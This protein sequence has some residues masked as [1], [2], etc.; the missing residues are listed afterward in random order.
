MNE[1]RAATC[2]LL[3]LQDDATAAVRCLRRLVPGRRASKRRGERESVLAGVWHVGDGDVGSPPRAR[4][5]HRRHVLLRRTTG[6]AV[7]TQR[8]LPQVRNAMGN[9]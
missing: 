2:A 7:H 1:K 9:E 3:L 5:L 6:P 8:C 4:Q